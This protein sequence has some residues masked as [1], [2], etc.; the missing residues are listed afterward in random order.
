MEPGGR[1]RW[2]PVANGMAQKRRRQAETV[3]ADCDRLPE[4]F[5][6]K[7]GVDFAL[8]CDGNDRRPA[9]AS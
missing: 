8:G 5:H 3:A 4:S 9:F 6:G 7:E 2:Q 1:N